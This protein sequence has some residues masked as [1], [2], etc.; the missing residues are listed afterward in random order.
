VATLQDTAAWLG[1][2]R[3]IETRLYEVMGG[4]VPSTANP[5]VK[6][7]LAA[8]CYHHAWHAEVWEGLFP[9]GYGMDLDEATSATSP[10]LVSLFHHLAGCVEPEARLAALYRAVL[11][12]KIAA[13]RTWRSR[14]NPVTDGALVRWLQL[15]LV[16]E[17][18]DW[19]AGEFALQ[20]VLMS[21]EAVKRATSAQSEVETSLIVGGGLYAGL[22]N[23]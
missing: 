10:E 17:V 21:P 8:Q 5:E 9:T 2:S 16:D 4:W 6:A 11:P 14:A 15:V 7:L 12:R 20:Q 19:Q 1:R 18:D 3:W 13:Y 22:P 23:L